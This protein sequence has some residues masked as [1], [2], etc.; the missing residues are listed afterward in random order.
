MLASAPVPGDYDGNG[1]V[2]AADYNDW[3]ASFGQAVPPSTGA[4]GNGSGTINAADYVFW[5][6]RLGS[7]NGSGSSEA[8]EAA[9]PEPASCALA[10][11]GF[12]AIALRR[13]I[14]LAPGSA[15][16]SA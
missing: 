8:F 5:R 9:V 2:D 3:R 13:R 14:T 15:R 6:D 11:G 7:G 4:D 12:A 10:L 1:M 16:G